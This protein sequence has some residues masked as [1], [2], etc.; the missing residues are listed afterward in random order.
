[1]PVLTPALSIKLNRGIR[2]RLA[3]LQLTLIMPDIAV[4]DQRG[5]VVGRFIFRSAASLS[6]ILGSTTTG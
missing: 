1:M 4:R 5:E 3:L 6:P 2:L